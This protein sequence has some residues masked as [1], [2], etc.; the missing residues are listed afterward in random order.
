MSVFRHRSA[1]LVAALVL[2]VSAVAEFVRVDA[3]SHSV[4]DTLIRVFP[5]WVLCLVAWSLVR[6]LG[7]TP[8]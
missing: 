2:L 5:L 8:P 3:T 4:S 7:R 1:R 6:R